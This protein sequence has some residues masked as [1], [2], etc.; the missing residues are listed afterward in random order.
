MGDPLKPEIQ[1]LRT[2]LGDESDSKSLVHFV[3]N[4]IPGRA[5][6]EAILYPQERG[7]EQNPPLHKC[8]LTG[9]HFL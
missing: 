7:Q 2:A 6:W 3:L 5:E 4:W 8:G 1:V 9:N